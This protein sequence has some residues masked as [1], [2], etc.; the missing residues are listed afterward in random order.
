MPLLLLEVGQALGGQALGGQA[1][2]GQAW[3]GRAWG[4]R[5]W[6]GQAWGRQAL[7]ARCWGCSRCLNLGVK[8]LGQRRRVVLGNGPMLFVGIRLGVASKAWCSLPGRC[9]LSLI[10][11]STT[12]SSASMFRDMHNIIIT[13]ATTAAA[14]TAAAAI[15]GAA[16]MVADA[17]RCM[18]LIL[19]LSAGQVP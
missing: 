3:G 15:A 8:S 4:G 12:V 16:A 14:F 5:A 18:A 17:C 9:S 11:C 6:R 10:G 1:W 7:G 13:A 19:L 2:G